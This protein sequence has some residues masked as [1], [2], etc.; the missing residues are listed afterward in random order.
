[1]ETHNNFNELAN[2]PAATNPQGF[3][4]MVAGCTVDKEPQSN[5]TQF[6]GTQTVDVPTWNHPHKSFAYGVGGVDF[7]T[8]FYARDGVV[9]DKAKQDEITRVVSWNPFYGEIPA[10]FSGFGNRKGEII[11]Y[12]DKGLR[13][14]DKS[15][16]PELSGY[17]P[18]P[19]GWERVAE[20]T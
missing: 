1:M 14:C 7:C 16:V 19:K 3:S 12:D 8:E 2:S 18:L 4:S 13:I 17:F 11:V 6:N 20:I 5:M 15:D 10:G 9:P